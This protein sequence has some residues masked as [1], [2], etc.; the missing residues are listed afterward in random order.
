MRDEGKLVLG[1]SGR[2]RSGKSTVTSATAQAL[3]WPTASFGDFVRGE[4]ARRQLPV[5]RDA[6][7]TVG[8]ELISTLGWPEFCEL[9]LAQAGLTRKSVPCI[10]EGIR[11]VPALETLRAMFE[12]VPVYLV[13]VQTSEVERERRL[14]REGV[15]SE[16]A[17]AWSEHSTE[18]DVRDALPGLA[19]L[20][21]TAEDSP[22][23]AVDE[24]LAWLSVSSAAPGPDAPAPSR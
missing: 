9:T 16:R 19:D 2:I 21:V 11:H 12:P 17:A 4:A 24:I 20:C 6:L 1:F 10:I 15:S 23:T 13:H 3:G 22:D 18:R 5:D 14:R 7:Q 8:E